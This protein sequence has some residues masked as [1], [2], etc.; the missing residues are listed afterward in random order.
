MGCCNKRRVA[1][2]SA[3]LAGVPGRAPGP[4]GSARQVGRPA[5]REVTLRYTHGQAIR[6][7]GV[8]TGRVYEIPASAREVPV[9]GRDVAS[10]LRTRY[11]AR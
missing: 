8:A 4:T 10:L 1:M 9:D 3:A 11:F 5:A 7:R 2:R 6:V